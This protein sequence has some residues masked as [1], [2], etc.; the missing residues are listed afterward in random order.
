MSEDKNTNPLNENANAD[1]VQLCY[2]LYLSSILIVITAPVGLM[3]AYLNKAGAPEW[4]Q[5]HYVY[6][7]HTFWK[8]LLYIVISTILM[9][10]LIGFLLFIAAIAWWIIRC[11]KGLKLLSKRQPIE[12]PKGWLL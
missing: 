6:I 1:T 11:I 5:T 2:I 7:I 4:L 9:V 3:M 12:D 10:V 8:G